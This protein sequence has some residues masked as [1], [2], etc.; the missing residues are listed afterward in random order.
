LKVKLIEEPRLVL[1]V[2]EGGTLEMDDAAY[3]R[4][5]WVEQDQLEAQR[6]LKSLITRKEKDQT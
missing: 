1:V 2:R 5:R 4:F 3:A 6:H